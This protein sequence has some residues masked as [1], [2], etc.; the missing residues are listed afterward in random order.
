MPTV[1]ANICWSFIMADYSLVPVEHQPDFENVSLVPIDHD[2]FSADGVTQQAQFQQPQTQRQ[3]APQTQP[4]RSATGVGEPAGNWPATGDVPVGSS[5]GVGG[6][7]ARSGSKNPT[8]AP[9][10]AS[11]SN[12]SSFGRGLLQ[13]T[14]NAVV[15]G[16]YHSGL[17]QQQFR[18]GNYGA[19]T[20][21]GA[22]A[23]VDAVLGAA[24]L[25]ASTRLGA[26]VRAAKTLVPTATEGAGL[27]RTLTGSRVG[28]PENAPQTFYRGDQAGLTE[29]RSPAAQAGGH[30]NSEAVLAKG[31]MNDLMTK[32]SLDSRN[33][34]SPYISVTTDP[35]VARLHGDTTYR[36][37]LAPGRAIPNPSSLYSESEHL[38][39]HYISPDE[40]K[41]TLP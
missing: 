18:Q 10:S 34:P 39:P 1:P 24:T 19:A 32:H 35:N 20:L 40:I 29:F 31:D 27:G 9:A 33:P 15:P 13:G 22:E 4:Q 21:Y 41:G 36:L 16:A 3:Q 38:V 25:G 37:K 8:S 26:G 28:I 11:G 30:A 2:P 17:A 7:D 5:G 14:V 23:I 12:G 6:G